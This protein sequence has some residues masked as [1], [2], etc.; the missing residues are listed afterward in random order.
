MQMS[1]RSIVSVLMGILIFLSACSGYSITGGPGPLVKKS[2]TTE[3][4]PTFRPT[5]INVL[6]ILPLEHGT[7]ASFS[8]QTK[9][10][11][12]ALLIEAFHSGTSMEIVNA[13]QPKLVQ[14]VWSEIARNPLPLQTRAASYGSRLHSQGVLY[15]VINHYQQLQG[16]GYGASQTGAVGFK[17]WLLDITS[18]QVVWSATF[19][20]HEQPL[21]EN[22]FRVP[23]ALHDGVRY[24]SA[25][26]IIRTG[27][28]A[29]AHELEVLRHP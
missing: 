22:L 9:E 3:P 6:A 26:Q 15:G 20:N 18:N 14:N 10:M 24:H 1:S 16:S 25:E 8:P 19:N 4:S 2:L 23:Q 7:S 17:L 29:A 12:T 21:S 27:F 13:V 5:K 28:S 11:L